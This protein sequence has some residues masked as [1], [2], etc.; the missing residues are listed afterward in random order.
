[1]GA[2]IPWS[3]GLVLLVERSPG[4][5]PL[6]PDVI[7]GR[8]AGPNIQPNRSSS[9]DIS[10]KYTIVTIFHGKLLL[11]RVCCLQNVNS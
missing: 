10:V 5:S 4:L 6:K 11:F 2:G 3:I 8:G 7:T 1:M 9:Y